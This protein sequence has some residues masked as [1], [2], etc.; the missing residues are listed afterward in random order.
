M[1]EGAVVVLHHFT[2]KTA[3]QP[4]KGGDAMSVYD[5]VMLVLAIVGIMLQLVSIKKG[6]DESHL[7]A[8]GGFLCFLVLTTP[9]LRMKPTATA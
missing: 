5:A 7:F 4:A 3:P 8:V 9:S 6:Q 2:S 1:L